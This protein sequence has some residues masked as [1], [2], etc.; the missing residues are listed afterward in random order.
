MVTADLDGVRATRYPPGLVAALEKIRGTSTAM[1]TVPPTL[2]VLCFAAPTD[3]DGGF[4]VHP[5]VEDRID[6][7]RE[8]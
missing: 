4:A 2:S 3:G 8:I 6:L 7:L 1:P 5:P